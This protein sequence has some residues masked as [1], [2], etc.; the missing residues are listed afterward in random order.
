MSNVPSPSPEQVKI[1]GMIRM[2]FV[3]GVLL[4]GAVTY[5]IHRQGNYTPPGD[6][7]PFRMLVGA[8]MLVGAGIIGFGR[9]RLGK[10]NTLPDLQTSQLIGWAGGEMAALAGGVHYLL[11]G[12]PT[13]YIVGLFVLVGSLIVIPLRR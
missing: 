12:D 1:T 7:Q 6:S 9:M 2:S 11:T 8:A 5:F 4:L 3:M 13:A 10:A